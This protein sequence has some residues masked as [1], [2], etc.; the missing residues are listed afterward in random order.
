[1]FN[2]K[3]SR[4]SRNRN[5]LSTRDGGSMYTN[6]TWAACSRKG[7]TVVQPEKHLN[8]VDGVLVCSICYMKEVWEKEK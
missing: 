1:M 5:K 2:S 7:C 4:S 3:K 8:K 6:S